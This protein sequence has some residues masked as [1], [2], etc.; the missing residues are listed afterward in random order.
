VIAFGLVPGPIMMLMKK[1]LSSN[2]VKGFA[3]DILKEVIRADMSMH[4]AQIAAWEHFAATRPKGEYINDDLHEGFARNLFLSLAEL[5]LE[6]YVKPGGMN[7]FSR[8]RLAWKVLVRDAGVL[9]PPAVMEM[10]AKGDPNS[11][12]VNIVINRFR[13]GAVKATYSPADDLTDELLKN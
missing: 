4:V 7:F 5:K 11:V 12:Q 13:D 2:P 9:A 6:W 1:N 8:L 10:A 3:A